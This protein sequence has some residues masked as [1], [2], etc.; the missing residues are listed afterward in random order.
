MV[1]LVAGRSDYKCLLRIDI[2][3]H[4]TCRILASLG[5]WTELWRHLEVGQSFGLSWKLGRILVLF[6]IRTEFRR[7]L[8]IRQWS[9]RSFFPPFLLLFSSSSSLLLL[10]YCLGSPF[11]EK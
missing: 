10:P 3:L 4:I 8:R 7:H 1:M 6:G 9:R 11:L 5:S 2:Q